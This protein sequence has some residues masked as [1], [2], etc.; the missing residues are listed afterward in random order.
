MALTKGL[1]TKE[2][3]AQCHEAGHAG[4]SHLTF[5]SKG[6]KVY[7]RE[8]GLLQDRNGKMFTQNI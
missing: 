3:A 7:Y 2:I 1:V 4:F 8:R 5:P 6:S